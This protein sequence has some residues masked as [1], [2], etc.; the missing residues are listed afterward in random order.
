MRRINKAEQLKKIKFK[1]VNTR[2]S[3]ESNFYHRVILK[4]AIDSI[5]YLNKQLDLVDRKV[6][7]LFSHGGELAKNA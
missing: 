2:I 3:S 5:N 6:L 1:M 4:I 7:N